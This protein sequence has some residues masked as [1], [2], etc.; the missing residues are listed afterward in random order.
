MEE[1]QIN[2]KENNITTCPVCGEEN[3][4][5]HRFC[6]SCGAELKGNNDSID[7]KKSTANSTSVKETS[8]KKQK[9]NQSQEIV[10]EIKE[11]SV[12]QLSY[13]ITVLVVGGLIML[14]AAGMF[15]NPQV[16]A[17]A[18]TQNQQEQQSGVNLNNI[19]EINSLEETVKNNPGDMASLLKL[20]HLLN[21]S[22]FY[23]R[24]IDK[25]KTYL[26]KNK[27]ETDVWVDLGVCYYQLSDFTDAINAMQTALNISPDHQI[28]NFNMGIVN[29]AM[30]NHDA[31]I[32]Y[33]QKAVSIG[34]NS[35]IGKK[36][37]ELLKS[38]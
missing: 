33:W 17:S 28:A 27:K 21:D 18:V 3:P 11:I 4:G 37:E 7:K 6:S 24:A 31:A 32:K 5:N 25:Y 26:E 35:E 14:F 10:P 20:A 8:G 15:D 1:N 23:Q 12:K 29:L 22:G 38:H 16:P 30:N 19:N 34:P 2:N 13:L 36:A 9:K